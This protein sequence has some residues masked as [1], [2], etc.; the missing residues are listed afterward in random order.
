MFREL[1]SFTCTTWQYTFRGS[2]EEE[3]SG[4]GWEEETEGSSFAGAPPQEQAVQHTL[5]K[6][7]DTKPIQANR[8]FRR[9]SGQDNRFISTLPF[10]IFAGT[11]ENRPLTRTH[12]SVPY[13]YTTH[14]ETGIEFLGNFFIFPGS[15]PSE[16]F[17]RPA[18]PYYIHSRYLR[19]VS[20]CA[21]A[22]KTGGFLLLTQAGN[23][24]L[25]ESLPCPQSPVPS[26]RASPSPLRKLS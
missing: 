5:I 9:K 2:S 4:S 13:K 24:L 1:P 16:A 15:I 8:Q 6:R 22:A 10:P 11:R 17:F 12:G 7:T 19:P 18:H 14:W 21:A 26:G 23:I 20:P 3:A 25:P